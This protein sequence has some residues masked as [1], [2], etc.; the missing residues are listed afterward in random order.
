MLKCKLGCPDVLN[1]IL[2]KFGLLWGKL[3]YLSSWKTCLTP[4]LFG[5]Y[6]YENKHVCL[7]MI[8]GTFL[9][10]LRE[11]VFWSHRAFLVTLA[12]AVG[13]SSAFR[14]VS[15]L[16]SGFLAGGP[17]SLC[18]QVLFPVTFCA[19]AIGSEI[20]FPCSGPSTTGPC[21]SPTP[22]ASE[23]HPTPALPEPGCRWG[24]DLGRPVQALH[25]K[26]RVISLE[27]VTTLPKTVVV[28]A[29]ICFMEDE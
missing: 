16:V 21:A 1:P 3:K 9:D 10:F 4:K 20:A 8:G 18:F 2:I 12:T 25:P 6:F 7:I 26:A 5:F 19:A 23:Q 24:C 15:V 27:V 17:V 14:L 22:W 29:G 28:F 11:G 13:H